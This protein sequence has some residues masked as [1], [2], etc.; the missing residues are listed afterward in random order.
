MVKAMDRKET[1]FSITLPKNKKKK[2][3]I[4]PRT[5]TRMLYS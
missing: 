5:A 4:N 2:P 3:I 1:I